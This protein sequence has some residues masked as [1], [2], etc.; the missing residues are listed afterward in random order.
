M[1]THPRVQIAAQ[2]ELD[3]VIGN[4]R[5]TTVA[6]RAQLPY[7]DA[8]VKEVFRWGPIAP[9]GKPIFPV[10]PGDGMDTDYSSFME[11]IPHRLMQEDEYEGYRIPAGSFVLP[12]IW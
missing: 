10:V 11:A 7:I 12:N 3:A 2:V 1:C 9:L 5:L 4:E 8:V 6:D